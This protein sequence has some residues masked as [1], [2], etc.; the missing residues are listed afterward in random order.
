MSNHFSA[1]DLKCPG[2]DARLDLTDLFVFAAPDNPDRTV[3]IMDCNPFAKG[4]GFPPMRSTGSTSTPTGTALPDAAFSFTFSEYDNGRQTATAYYYSTGSHPQTPEPGGDMLVQAVPV[5]FDATATSLDAGPVRLFIGSRSDP[6]FD[7]AEGVVHWLVDGA[8]GDFQWTG[9]DTFADANI[10][11][12]VLEAPNDMLGG[13]PFGAWTTISLRRDGTLVPMDREGNPSFNPILN[14]NDIKDQ[15]DARRP[16]RRHHQL[17]IAAVA[18]PASAR[19]PAGRSHRRG[20]HPAA[21]HPSPRPRQASALSQRPGPDRRRPLH[22]HD[23]H[24]PRAE[25]SATNRATR[26]PAAPVPLP[27]PA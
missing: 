13:G 5:G 17:S 9:T 21:R 16:D 23:L 25:N 14:A 20:H 4:E 7:D 18:N 27:R 8:H 26:R 1:A 15:F 24:D 19:I 22:P 3:L 12:I 10:S 11:S 2:D 6:F